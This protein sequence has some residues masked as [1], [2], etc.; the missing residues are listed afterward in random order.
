MHAYLYTYAHARRPH[1][2][3]TQARVPRNHG[4]CLGQ[5]RFAGLL[6]CACTHTRTRTHTCASHPPSRLQVR[7]VPALGY[8]GRTLWGN[9][10]PELAAGKGGQGEQ[11][12]GREARAHVVLVPVYVSVYSLVLDW[13]VN[14]LLA[15]RKYFMLGGKGGVGKTSCS[16]SLAVTLAEA[17]H[18]TLVV[19]TDPAHSLSDSLDQVGGGCW[20]RV[21]RLSSW[22][23]QRG[24]VQLA[25]WQAGR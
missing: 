18:T 7:G 22:Q 10:A 17:G 13:L 24:R 21:F 25:T 19:S 6:R 3:A 23:G 2:C 20:A 5:H 15:G 9:F 8:F 11:S 14:W 4:C 1:R 12:T 16:A